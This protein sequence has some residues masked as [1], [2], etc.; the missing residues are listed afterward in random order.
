MD[1]QEQSKA[2]DYTA[3][4]VVMFGVNLG[5][6]LPVIFALWGLIGAVLAGLLLNGWIGWIARRRGRA[7]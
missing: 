5:W 1:R 4:C 7:R 3:A 2:P 6:A